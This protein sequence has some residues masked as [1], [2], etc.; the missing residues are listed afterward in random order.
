VG[1]YY[2]A[3]KLDFPIIAT[4]CIVYKLL[5]IINKLLAYIYIVPDD[6]DLDQ[7]PYISE[8]HLLLY[9]YI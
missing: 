2:C 4:F 1:T 5:Y 6:A 3:I 7:I 9:S 8:G